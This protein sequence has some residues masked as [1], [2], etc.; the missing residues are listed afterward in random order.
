VRVSLELQKQPDIM[1]GRRGEVKQ[2]N[3]AP[4]YQ[5]IATRYRAEFLKLCR[6]VSIDD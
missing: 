1:L 2:C 4:E 3:K 6:C 5:E